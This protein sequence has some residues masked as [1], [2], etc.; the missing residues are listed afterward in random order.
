MTLVHAHLI[1]IVL[2]IV[3]FVARTWRM[4]WLL[5]G[6]GHRLPFG[7]VFVHS[8]LGEAASSLTPLRLG[9]EPARIWAMTKAGVPVTLGV[10]GIGAEIIVMTPVT[11]IGAAALVVLLAPE[12][13]GSVGPAIVDGVRQSW[14]WV[15]ATGALIVVAWA[16]MRRLAPTAGAALRRE[17]AAARLYVRGMP[18]WPLIA[19]MP[20]TL[21]SAAAR[22]AILPVLALTL[23]YDLPLGPVVVG[24]FMLLYS[25][26]LLPTPAGAGVVE[27]GFLGGAAGEMGADETSLLIAWRFYT[28]ILGVVLGILLA[29]HR[30][31]WALL[32]ARRARGSGP[33]AEAHG[34]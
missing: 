26:L 25:Q 28:T 16:L 22:I 20:L 9:G 10:V 31:G 17:V 6:L 18:R 4:Q 14:R 11:L 32:L 24:S 33:A 12:W 19:S 1:C 15:V 23:S 8:V 34:Q 2:V 21:L 13:W 7:E 5:K 27:L 30:Y 3:D 29:G